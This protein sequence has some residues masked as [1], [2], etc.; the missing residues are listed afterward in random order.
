MQN[1]DNCVQGNNTV[2]CIKCKETF[3]FFNE[4]CTTCGAVIDNCINCTQDTIE[5]ALCIECSNGYLLRNN[6]CL[7]CDDLISNCTAC[8]DDNGTNT[9]TNCQPTYFL[10]TNNC[11]LCSS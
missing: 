1:C 8:K 3:Y 4:I 10:D 6:L 2:S 7:K 11:S 5:P 9:C